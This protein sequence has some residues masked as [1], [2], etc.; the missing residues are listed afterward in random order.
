MVP[1]SRG[2]P[3]GR[4]RDKV[5]EYVCERDA[6]RREGLDQARTDCLERERWRHFCCGHSP[7][8]TFPEGARHQSYREIDK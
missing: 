7:G 8:G 6:T 3:H 4:W 5:K 2:R 1:R